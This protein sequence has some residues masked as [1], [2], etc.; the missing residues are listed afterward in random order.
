MVL[1]VLTQDICG[2]NLTFKAEGY[3]G[4]EEEK[5]S[6]IF[7]SNCKC[8]ELLFILYFTLVWESTI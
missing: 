8:I 7:L 2:T 3:L 5:I 6:R 4:K 1:P